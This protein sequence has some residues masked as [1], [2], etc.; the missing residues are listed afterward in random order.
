MHPA[1]NN[2][3]LRV[4]GIALGVLSLAG[5]GFFS[6]YAVAGMLYVQPQQATAAA[7]AAVNEPNAF[8]STTLIA[9]SAYVVDLKTGQVLYQQNADAQLPLASLTKIPL[10]LV[11][12]SVLPSDT[13]V[14]IPPHQTPDATPVRIPAGSEWHLQ[15]LID[16]T[17]VPSSNEGAELLAGAANSAVEAQYPDAPTSGGDTATLWRMNS[18]A[19]QL[20]LTNTYFLD[21]TGLDLSTTQSGAYGSAKDVEKIFAYA[22]ST[23]PSVFAATTQNEVERTTLEGQTLDAKNTDAA[24]P[25]IP[26]LIMGK[27]GYTDLAGGNLAVAFNVGPDHTVVAIVMGSTEDGRFSD[28]LE[29]VPAAEAAVAEGK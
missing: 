18:L 13:I 10:M 26:G 1:E 25:S 14:T 20:G 8:A 19:Q 21:V 17:L 3:L 27:T 12:T 28:M 15:D 29:L 23:S 7:A 9:K 22:L 16:F 5:V 4:A 24:L 6:A 11:V 2:P